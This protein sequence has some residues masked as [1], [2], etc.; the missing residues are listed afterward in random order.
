M[1]CY[2]STQWCRVEFILQHGCMLQKVWSAVGGPIALIGCFTFVEMAAVTCRYTFRM[3]W[4]QQLGS[5]SFWPWS[6]IWA[7]LLITRLF[8]VSQSN[9]LF[10]CAGDN[11]VCLRLQHSSHL[12]QMLH[13]SIPVDDDIILIAGN[14]HFFQN[15]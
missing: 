15:D 4:L 3:K 9:C 2:A 7:L 14:I 11:P 6:I 8:P 10:P 5:L 12:Q 1:K 13:P